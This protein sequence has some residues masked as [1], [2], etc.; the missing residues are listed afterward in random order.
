MIGVRT[1]AKR[2]GWRRHLFHGRLLLDRLP[3]RVLGIE[4]AAQIQQSALGWGPERGLW[5]EASPWRTLSSVLPRSSVGPTDVFVDFGC[6]KGRVLLQAARYPFRKVIGVELSPEVA[7]V[8]RRN[9]ARVRRYLA[10]KDV[11]VVTDDVAEFPIPDDL[12]VAFC[13]NPATGAIFKRLL[14]NLG[15]SLERH[16]RPFQL[17]Y[18]NPAMEGALEEAGWSESRR[19][20]LRRPDC[21]C[22]MVVYR[23]DS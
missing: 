23:K 20:S 22:D 18:H 19:I 21:R 14:A 3:D 15:Q 11:E 10:C 6:G 12:T 8:G 2:V 16:P 7:D 5:Y 9:V 1:L 17:I 4:T 13:F